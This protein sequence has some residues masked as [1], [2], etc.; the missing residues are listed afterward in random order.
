MYPETLDGTEYNERK[1]C[2]IKKILHAFLFFRKFVKGGCK[3]PNMYYNNKYTM[4]LR[5]IF[6]N[7]YIGLL[8]FHLVDYKDS[9]SLIGYVLKY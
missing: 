1:A 3:I 4:K 9:G 7:N 6:N 2:S 5:I 8:I